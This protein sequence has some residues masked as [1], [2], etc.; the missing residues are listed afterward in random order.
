MLT[1]LGPTIVQAMV[2][3]MLVMLVQGV[4]KKLK[5]CPSN[6]QIIKGE[7]QKEN[8]GTIVRGKNVL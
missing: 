6:V 7:K 2:G 8:L 1:A 5:R 3:V 4:F